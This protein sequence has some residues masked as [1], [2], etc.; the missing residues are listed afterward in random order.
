[1]VRAR[2]VLLMLQALSL[3]GEVLNVFGL[4]VNMDPAASGSSSVAAPTGPSIDSNH[5]ATSAE[6]LER[7][8]N[9]PRQ[10]RRVT[11]GLTEVMQIDSV[12]NKTSRVRLPLTAGAPPRS[13]DKPDATGVTGMREH[14]ADRPRQ[15]ISAKNLFLRSARRNEQRRRRHEQRARKEGQTTGQ[16]SSSDARPDSQ[17][18]I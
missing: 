1:M 14:P 3:Q 11:F 15:M 12:K 17:R 5:S 2:L 9:V 16:R 6:D 18:S 4:R 10:Q 13:E 8:T 7:N